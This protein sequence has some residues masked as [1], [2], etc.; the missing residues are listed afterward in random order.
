MSP[1]TALAVCSLMQSTAY[2][3]RTSDCL[4]MTVASLG[5]LF[6]SCSCRDRCLTALACYMDSGQFDRERKSRA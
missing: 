3:L 2:T 6:F 5:G 4:L 1:T